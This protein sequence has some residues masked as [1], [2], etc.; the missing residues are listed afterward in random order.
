MFL[1]RISYGLLSVQERTSIN[2]SCRWITTEEYINTAHYKN[3]GIRKVILQYY[4]EPT[5]AL[6]LHIR[7]INVNLWLVISNKKFLS[8]WFLYSLFITISCHVYT[9]YHPLWWQNRSRVASFHIL[10]VFRRVISCKVLYVLF[11]R[12]SIV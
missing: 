11:S 1:D 4:K 9:K 2:L 3:G 12:K 7:V 8:T 10:I 6:Y 5:V